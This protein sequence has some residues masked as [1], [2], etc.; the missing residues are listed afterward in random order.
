MSMP[1]YASF[2]AKFKNSTTLWL[3][4]LQFTVNLFSRNV[5][6][7]KSKGQIIIIVSIPACLVG[8]GRALTRPEMTQLDP[9]HIE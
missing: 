3:K 5:Q 7:V 1:S 2:E 6:K 4:V 8:V 9:T